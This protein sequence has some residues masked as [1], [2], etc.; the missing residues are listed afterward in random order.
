MYSPGL[1]NVISSGA[2]FEIAGAAG[3]EAEGFTEARSVERGRRGSPQK[4]G[5]TWCILEYFGAN[6]AHFTTENL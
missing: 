4:I 6:N 2:R 1:S 5:S 3:F